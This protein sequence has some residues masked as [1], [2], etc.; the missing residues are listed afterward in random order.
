MELKA[1]AVNNR[2]KLDWEI[3]ADESVISQTVEVATDGVNFQPL[4]LA[5]AGARSF[6]YQP[7]KSTLLYYRLNVTFDNGRR[8]YSN[9]AALRGNAANNKPFLIGN[10]I[11]SNLSVNSPSG[12]TYT[13]VDLGGRTLAKGQ[14]TQGVNNIAAGFLPTGLYILQ[15]VN[16]Q[17]H[18]TEKFMKK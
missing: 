8:Y 6:D 5:A 17:E 2:H 9:I 4:S 11:T 14:L 7:E 16:N 13:I 18:Y 1:T 12:F 15:F 3:I 10:L